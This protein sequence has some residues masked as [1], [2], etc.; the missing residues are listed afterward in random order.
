MRE[1]KRRILSI[2][3]ALALVLGLCTPL[4]G[5]LPE[6]EAAEIVDSG[7]CGENMTWTLDSEGTLTFNGD[8]YMYD[9]GPNT[10]KPDWSAEDTA[11]Y[12]YRD[13]IRSVVIGEGILLMC[14][15]AFQDCINLTSVSLPDSLTGISLH[16][17]SGCTSLTRPC[18]K[19]KSCTRNQVMRSYEHETI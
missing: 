14:S 19:N 18:L 10:V 9:E 11:W 15:Y 4:G 5:L 7:I 13:E 8:G 3:T 6:A 1:G 17:F 2:L 12:K 16:G